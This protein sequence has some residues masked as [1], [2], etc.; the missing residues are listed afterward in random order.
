MN[1]AF[2]E[3]GLNFEESAAGITL[4]PAM[5]LFQFPAGTPV[6][7]TLSPEADGVLVTRFHSEDNSV[8]EVFANAS[9]DDALAV[10]VVELT[11][12]FDLDRYTRLAA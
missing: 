2:L 7:I 11:D 8:G 9:L 1:N 10:L 5:D 6:R 4:T 3:L 12:L